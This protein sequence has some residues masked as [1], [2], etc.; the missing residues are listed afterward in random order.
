MERKLRAIELCAGA[1]GQALGIE[2]AG[3]DHV[4]LVENDP[5]ACATLRLNRPSWNVLECDL[6][7][8]SAYGMENI[9]LVAGGVPCQPFSIG[10]KQLGQQDERDLFPE[11]LRVIEECK[12]RGILLENVR[13]LA[14]TKFSSYRTNILKRLSKLGYF[15][16]WKVI[17]AVDYGVPQYRL[18]FILVGRLGGRVPFPWI[19]SPPKERTVSETIYDLM[20]EKGWKQIGKWSLM[21]NRPAPCLVGGS[22]KHGGPDLGPQ[23]AKREWA[24][25]YVNGGGV[26]NEAPAADFD[27][28]PKLTVRMTARLQGF[29]DDWIFHGG[30]TA[31][32]RQIGNAFP[33]Q[34]AHEL[35][36]AMRQWLEAPDS[37][38]V[39]YLAE[40]E[41]LQLALG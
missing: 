33:S 13:G 16:E 28:M 25:M 18:R 29:P 15:C 14:G 1:G 26:A 5:N 9:D 24:S 27:G 23:R 22:K 35:G 36:L 12:P 4:A 31:A 21:A 41:Q 19:S 6:K 11:A 7:N 38:E 3:F 17:N 32:Y 30:K 10:G 39:P 34:V 37:L 8:F 20:N 2:R 40:E